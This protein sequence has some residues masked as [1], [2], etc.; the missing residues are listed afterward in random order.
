MITI[1][2]IDIT[3]KN[4]NFF[5]PQKTIARPR[6]L[7]LN[8]NREEAE[9]LMMSISPGLY[10]FRISKSPR[11]QYEFITLS[12]ANTT[13]APV[14]FKIEYVSSSR[15]PEYFGVPFFSVQGYKFETLE[16]LAK[17]FKM[18]KLSFLKNGFN[19]RLISEMKILP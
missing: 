6:G 10:M 18:N 5:Q 12:I 7:F 9:S 11:T 13:G 3:K 14:H 8:I 17:F 1:I 4:N 16:E 15:S 2:Y 19:F